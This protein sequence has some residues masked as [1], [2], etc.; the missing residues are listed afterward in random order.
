MAPKIKV[1]VLCFLSQLASAAEKP[2]QLTL[3]GGASEVRFTALGKPSLLRIKGEGAHANGTLENQGGRYTGEISVDLREFHTG[4]SLRDRHMKEKYLE[5]GK[6]EFAKAVLK[7]ATLDA[8]CVEAAAGS[9]KPC[10]FTGSL[11]LHGKSEPVSGTAV[12][13]QE[14]NAKKISAEWS[15]KL[16]NHGIE[17]PTFAGVTVADDVLVNAEAKAL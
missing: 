2:A 7:I 16:S 5:L 14:G 9:S 4:I 10:A 3:D 15:F 17:I 8:P 13:S 12:V 11:S 1:F 6:A